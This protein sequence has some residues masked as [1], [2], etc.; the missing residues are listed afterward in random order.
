MYP[1]GEGYVCH[2]SI[3]KLESARNHAGILRA[4]L[5]M[6]FRVVLSEF[7]RARQGFD[8]LPDCPGIFPVFASTEFAQ[9]ADQFLEV[10]WPILLALQKAFD[11]T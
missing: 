10:L 7:C 5:A 9:S 3:R 2:L 6:S 1:P 4:L 11:V 8:R